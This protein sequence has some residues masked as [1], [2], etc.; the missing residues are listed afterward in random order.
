ML[1]NQNEGTS[2]QIKNLRQNFLL[3]TYVYF[4]GLVMQFPIGT[5][6]SVTLNYIIILPI[7]LELK[8]ILSSFLPSF[9]Y[10]F[11]LY[12][13]SIFSPFFPSF[14]LLTLSPHPSSTSLGKINTYAYDDKISRL[15]YIKLLLFFQLKI[16]S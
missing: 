11:L 14:L 7:F 8:Y 9:R 4:L 2:Q 16:Q 10:F 13:L 12:F 1:E 3:P 6:L 15:R 5:I